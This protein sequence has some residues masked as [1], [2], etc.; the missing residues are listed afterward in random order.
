MTR[1]T[2]E[3]HLHAAILPAHLQRRVTV[4]ENVHIRVLGSPVWEENHAV[5]SGWRVQNHK[6]FKQLQRVNIEGIKEKEKDRGLK[7]WCLQK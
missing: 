7:Y 1:C 4:L 5:M 3:A 6:M 2:Q